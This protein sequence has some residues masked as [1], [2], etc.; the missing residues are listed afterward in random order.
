MSSTKNTTNHTVS[1]MKEYVNSKSDR[2]KLN[3]DT[4]N[5]T[6]QQLTDITRPATKNIRTTDKEQIRN[7]LTGNIGA[8][9]QGL[10]RASRYLLYRSHIY[11]RL[12]HF[13]ADMLDLNCR[14][15]IPKFDLT[16]GIDSKK[17]LKQFNDTLDFLEIMNFQN[18]SNEILMNLWT[19]DVYYGIFYHDE[20]GSFFYNLDADDCRIIGRYYTGDLSFALDCRAWSSRTKREIANYLGEP[21]TSMLKEYE[22]T[23]ERYIPVP[24]EYC[25]CFKFRTDTLDAII[26]PFVGL[27]P[28]LAGLNDLVDLQAIADDQQIYK[29]V[30]LPMKVLGGAKESDDFEISPDLMLK[31]FNRLVD[32]ALPDYVASAPIPGDEL[33][34]IDF[35]DKTSAEVDRVSQSQS[36]ILATAGGGAV[37][38]TTRITSTAAFN[39]WL[40]M[41]SEFAISSI[42]PQL[43][44]FT[45][46]M[47]AYNVNNPCKVEYFPITI[48]TKSDFTENLLKANQYSYSYR[49]GLGTLF[50]YSE[51][52]TIA[53]LEFENQVLNLPETMRYPLQSSY[54]LSG[55]EVDNTGGRP[56]VSDDEITEEGSR[57]RDYQ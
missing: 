33:K 48:Y 9:E 43:E 44:G 37:L 20:T 54:T 16:K 21:F 32:E 6:L 13:Y 56:T 26:P 12:I 8:N 41:E 5:T 52:Q 10:R 28:S 38:D 4:A 18:N 24:D 7:Y 19:E 42:L 3:Y 36:T 1:E 39:A 31:Y 35:T 29:L 17:S 30:Y 49:L 34:T 50:G 51:K 57:S 11:F 47:L 15:V 53:M 55:D 40:K 45:N 2:T 46:R 14:K 25:V 22:R 27:F 23:G